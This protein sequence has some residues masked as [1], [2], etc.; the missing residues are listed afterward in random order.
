VVEANQPRDK[1]PFLV[2]VPSYDNLSE[3]FL[4]GSLGCIDRYEVTIEDQRRHRIAFYAKTDGA[5]RIRTPFGWCR[6]YCFGPQLVEVSNF[7]GILA[8][9]GSIKR[10]ELG[11][12]QN[13]SALRNSSFFRPHG[14]LARL[15]SR[16]GAN[17]GAR[18]AG[19]A[20]GPKY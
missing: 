1:Q 9:S 7:F 14:R 13:L 18:Q 6:P 5:S 10:E 16:L 19:F 20:S 11:W 3:Q 15:L 8:G 4:A 12:P 2:S 17:G